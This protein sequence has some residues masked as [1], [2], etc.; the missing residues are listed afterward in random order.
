MKPSPTILEPRSDAEILATYEVMS[1][2]RPRLVREDFVK[3]IRRLMD[4]EGYRLVAMV[5]DGEVRAVAGY[6]FLEMLYCG[7]FLYVDDLVTDEAARSRE[8]GRQLLGW[9]RTWLAPGAARSCS[10]I[11]PPTGRP[12]T[13]FM[14]E[15]EWKRPAITLQ[16]SCEPA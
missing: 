11:R 3:L 4:Q 5:E 6:R 1:Q 10:W 12:R 8:F 13:A 15:R 2:L 7:R 9:L 14:R 16:L